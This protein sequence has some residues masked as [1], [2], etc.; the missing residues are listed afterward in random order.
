MKRTRLYARLGAMIALAALALASQGV[1]SA[2]TN[3]ELAKLKADPAGAFIDLYL[4]RPEAKG[5]LDAALAKVNEAQARVNEVLNKLKSLAQDGNVLGQWKTKSVCV[6]RSVTVKGSCKT[7]A[8]ECSGWALPQCS[9]RCKKTGWLGICVSYEKTN[10]SSPCNKWRSTS[11]CLFWWPDSVTTQNAC[12]D[13]RYF[14]PTE[15]SAFKTARAEAESK[16]EAAR[17]EFEKTKSKLAQDARRAFDDTTKS[18]AQFAS[19]TWTAVSGTATS[20]VAKAG[21]GLR[22]VLVKIFEF[23]GNTAVELLDPV[24]QKAAQGQASRVGPMSRAPGAL[25]SLRLSPRRVAASVCGANDDQ[26]NPANPIAMIRNGITLAAKQGLAYVRSVLGIRGDW[27]KLLGVAEV[28]RWRLIKL[29]DEMGRVATIVNKVANFLGGF[30]PKFLFNLAVKAKEWTS[31]RKEEL[32]A[33]LKREWQAAEAT[34]RELAD[35]FDDL[36]RGAGAMFKAFAAKLAAGFEEAGRSLAEIAEKTGRAV[37]KT[38]RAVAAGA[39]SAVAKLA[40]KA[41]PI[42]S[43]LGAALRKGLTLLIVAGGP[44]LWPTL[45]WLEKEL[46]PIW[47]SVK[48]GVAQL[49]VNNGGGVWKKVLGAWDSLKA[50]AASVLEHLGTSV[51]AKAAEVGAALKK[52][53]SLI[54]GAAKK[55]GVGPVLVAIQWLAIGAAYP[56]ADDQCK[57]QDNEAKYRSCFHENF[58]AFAQRAFFDALVG[59][60]VQLLDAPITALATGVT[61]AVSAAVALAFTPPTAM[62]AGAVI[63][64][65]TKFGAIIGLTIAADYSFDWYQKTIWSGLEGSFAADAEKGA[66]FYWACRHTH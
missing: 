9:T 43:K 16:L 62:A 41:A 17:A 1:G 11:R 18:V 12:S 22:D 39:K 50:V 61:A 28:E 31:L 49:F 6:P 23:S 29:G 20:L 46:T 30:G 19:T 5:P 53:G 3:P 7:Y 54:A 36:A 21:A 66:T 56:Y 33:W 25:A 26:S 52:A 37:A 58:N 45:A 59:T 63:G 32:V 44:L 64:M 35:V 57:T 60:A 65:A 24:F 48:T 47:E 51:A 40:V 55:L 2:G 42:L 38:G 13:V 8:Q 34:A 27:S 14:D 15:G 10:C 4:G